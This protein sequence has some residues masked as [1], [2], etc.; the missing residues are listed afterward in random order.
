MRFGN[1]ATS[2]QSTTGQK[3]DPLGK[4]KAK[5]PLNVFKPHVL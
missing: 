2:L 3:Y 4:K 5:Y 1:T